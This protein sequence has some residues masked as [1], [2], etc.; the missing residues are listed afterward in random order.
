[1]ELESYLNLNKEEKLS[2]F[3]KTIT[4]IALPATFWFNFDKVRDNMEKYGP[5]LFTLDY[6]I[7]K[8]REDMEKL[9]I[10]R[11][12]LLKMIPQFLGIRDDRFEKVGGQKRGEVKQKILKIQGLDGEYYLNFSD[13]DVKNLSLYFKFIYASGLD[14]IFLEGVSKSIHDYAIGIETGMD[15]NGRKNRGGKLGEVLLEE[16]LKEFTAEHS[17]FWWRGQTKRK[18]I[19]DNYAI[20]IGHAF[21]NRRFDASLFDTRTKKLFLFEINNFSSQGSKL[22]ASG[23]EFKTL[24]EEIRALGH[25]FIYI[26]DGQGW[27]SDTSHLIDILYEIKTVF[28]YKMIADNYLSEYILNET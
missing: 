21:D 10:E 6:L 24:S 4:N 2:Y 18:D 23:A 16:Y 12:E 28:N 7:G 14:Y 19:I 9:F 22:K 26:T 25:E 5:D 17:H 20:D 1:M 11:P 8:T 27:K 15:S 3:M 13:I